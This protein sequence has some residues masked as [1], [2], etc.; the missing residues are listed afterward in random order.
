MVSRRSQASLISPLQ[1]VDDFAC[2]GLILERID[3]D[4]SAVHGEQFALQLKGDRRRI[5]DVGQA[6]QLA[7]RKGNASETSWSR[8][9]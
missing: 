6:T 1:P 8:W 5:L 9:A 3:G 7:F 2:F 4:L